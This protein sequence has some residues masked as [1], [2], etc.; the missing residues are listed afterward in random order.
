MAPETQEQIACGQFDLVL[1]NPPFGAAI[2]ITDPARLRQYR[3]GR[4]WQQ[5]NH[6]WQPTDA[7]Q[8]RQQPQ[9]LFLERCPGLLRDRSRLGLLLPDGN[10]SNP[11]DR[12]IREYIAEKAAI[13][14]AVGL[15]PEIFQPY[16][17]IKTSAL[18]LE[19]NGAQRSIFMAVASTAGRDK[20]GRP[21]YRMDPVTDREIRDDAVAEIARVARNLTRQEG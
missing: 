12:Y 6:H 19:K 10:L 20:K 11:A 18:F 17:S 15:P 7:I 2:P 9:I 16:A 5:W 14:G 21:L 1:A 8:K 3:L 4:R 13:L